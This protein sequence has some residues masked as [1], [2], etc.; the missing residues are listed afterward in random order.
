MLRVKSLTTQNHSTTTTH[1]HHSPIINTK[2]I[3]QTKERA[4]E[5]KEAKKEIYKQNQFF[6]SFNK[7]L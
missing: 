4:N 3:N 5:E 7:C 6:N 2:N 1:H